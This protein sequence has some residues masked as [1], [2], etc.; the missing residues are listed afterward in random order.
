VFVWNIDELLQHLLPAVVITPTRYDIIDYTLMSIG[1]FSCIKLCILQDPNP[2][3]M[4]K[5]VEPLTTLQDKVRK[6][7]EEWPDHPGLMKIL[8]TIASL[9]AMPLSTPISKVCYPI[10]VYNTNMLLSTD[11]FNV[12]L[13]FI[14]IILKAL[15]GL[16][17]LAGKAQTLQENDT[18]FF[19]KGKLESL[20]TYVLQLLLTMW[21]SSLHLKQGP[22]LSIY[23]FF[24]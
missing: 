18:K 15:L 6:Y 9:L 20:L 7:L 12:S 21:L 17:L 11:L 13:I 22:K 3:V 16:Q 5:M 2:S 23:Y 14:I 8:D 10:N 19:L 1:F 4:F 24:F